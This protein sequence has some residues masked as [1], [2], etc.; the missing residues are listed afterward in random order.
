ML[1]LGANA[2]VARPIEMAADAAKVAVWPE[3]RIVTPADRNI[4]PRD[5]AELAAGSNAVR[6]DSPN[7]VLG[8]GMRPYWAQFSLHNA[9]DAAQ[10]RVLVLESTTQYDTRLFEYDESGA[11]RQVK[12]VADQADGRIGGGTTSPRW[13]LQ[14]APLRTSEFLLRLEGPSLVRFPVFAYAP[15][16]FSERIRM[17]HVALGFAL[18]SCLFIGIYILSLRRYLE[19]RS[20]PLFLCMLIGDL[21]GAVWL[22]GAL[23]AMFPALPET[24]LSQ[25]GFAGFAVLFGCGCMHARAYLNTA[26]WF[27]RLDRMLQVLGWVWLALAPW[28]TVPFPVAARILL[29]WGGTAIALILVAVSVLAARRKSAQSGFVAAAWVSNLLMGF[30]FVIARAVDNPLTW[31]PS[32]LALIQATAMAILFGFAMSQR[33][34]GQ[35]VVLAAARQEAVMQKEQTVVRMRER[36]RVFAATSHDLRQPLLGVSMFAELLKSARTPEQRQEHM[37]KLDMALAEVDGLLV[38]IQQLAEVHE[39]SSSPAFVSVKIDDLLQPIIEE[40]RNRS[41]FKHLTIR[42]VP[43]GLSIATHPPYFQRIVRNVLS[44]AIRYTEAGDRILV[45]CRRGGDLRLVVVDT[46]R[47]MTEEQTRRAFDA[48]RRLETDTSATDGFGLGLFSV[49]TLAHALGLEVTLHSQAGRG[50]EFRLFL[51]P[52][53]APRSLHV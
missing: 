20:V 17:V 39:R 47:G 41:K 37:R 50:T 51:R 1:L 14:F 8:R 7:R 52:S 27:P 38:G 6:V 4:A 2:A 11:W 19:D 22:S 18:G 53:P 40:Y 26:A 3:M 28:F 31:S 15:S 49:K 33:L 46:G 35:R 23:G 29:V 30:Y 12:S 44:N 25:I 34:V 32:S 10:L 13:M 36:S 9:E 43:S 16:D 48:F 5:A 24:M 45:G 21:V 42:Y